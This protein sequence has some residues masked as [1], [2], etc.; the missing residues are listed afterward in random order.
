MK[1][2]DIIALG[3]MTFSL[4]LGAGNLIFPPMIG[5]MAGD[6][7][8][9][10]GLGFI[11]GD[12]GLTL[13]ALIAISRIGGPDKILQ[14]FPNSIQ[15]LFWTTLFIIIGPAFVLPRASIV[16]YEIGLHPILGDSPIAFH[17]FVFIF[18]A[19]GMLLTLNPKR[20]VDTI[21]KWMTPVLL[22]LLT[23]IA[24]ATILSPHSAIE[25]AR[26][27][28]INHAFSEGIIQGYLTMDALGALGFGWILAAA[29]RNLGY[30]SNKEISRYTAI[31]GVSAATGMILVYCA[32]LYLGA[33]S[34]GI[35][36]NAGNGG[37]IL[38]AYV[39]QLF[40]PFGVT[41]LAIV[42]ILACMTTCIGVSGAGAE[43]FHKIVPGFSYRHFVIIIFSSASIVATIGLEKLI[44]I[45]LPI[46]LL[47]YPVA[48]A[49]ILITLIRPWLAQP[50][51]ATYILSST[52]LTFGLL[53][54]AMAIGLVPKPV[55]MWLNNHLP[56]FDSGMGWV[57]PGC[58]AL[59][60]GIACSQLGLGSNA[61]NTN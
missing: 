35:A 58:I 3:L 1:N 56:L 19:T 26:G 52:A 14:D 42:F 12:I 32:M 57:I 28:Y 18:L 41:V 40:G 60:T 48:I 55:S 13:L 9:T 45:T 43:Y 17:S 30:T 47:F 11:I 16:T 2:T 44:G 50:Q 61:N 37:H 31:A 5:Q 7:T 39:S 36:P 49:V 10:A 51:K 27:S 6:N 25:P 54:G 29:I 59:I 38:S 4:F 23:T 22:L 15:N 46:I 24:V 53:D 21:G 33:T 20:I 8:L 34:Y